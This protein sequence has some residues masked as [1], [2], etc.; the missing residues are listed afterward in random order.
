MRRQELRY[1]FDDDQVD[2]EWRARPEDIAHDVMTCD[3]PVC[4]ETARII[5]APRARAMKA[6]TEV[7]V[8][9]AIPAE[10]R[11]QSRQIR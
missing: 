1:E 8:P 9:E 4:R 5:Q 7:P 11:K 10:S 2:G 3:K 6:K